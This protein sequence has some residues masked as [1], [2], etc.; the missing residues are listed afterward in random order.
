MN[1]ILITLDSVRASHLGCYGY[2]GTDTSVIDQIAGE[3]VLFENAFCQ[4]PNTWVSHASIFTGCNPNVH[5]LRLY[6]S[7]LNPHIP[8]L[9][10]ILRTAGYS[11]AGFPAHSLVGAVRG[12]QRGFEL[13]DEEDMLHDSV[14]GEG[15]KQNRAWQPTLEKAFRWMSTQPR[16]F[17]LWLHYMG[18]HWEPSEALSV[19]ESVRLRYSSLG[20]FYDAKISYADQVCIGALYDFLLDHGLLDDTLLVI[21]A[22][23]GED[24]LRK[25]DPPFRNQ[26][27]NNGLDEQVMHVPLII[28]APRLFPAGI[29]IEPVVRTVDI[30]PTLLSVLGIA[31]SGLA[32]DGIDLTAM[33]TGRDQTMPG[34]SAYMENAYKGYAGIRTDEW[35]L[36]LRVG[37]PPKKQTSLFDRARRR[38]GNE[39]RSLL[40]QA[41]TSPSNQLI[42]ERFRFTRWVKLDTDGFY[43]IA[44]DPHESN[45]LSGTTNLIDIES[46]L[47][48]HVLRMVR[49]EYIEQPDLSPIEEETIM[50]TLQ[51]LGYID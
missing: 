14:M 2:R 9:A 38:L 36:V 13:F 8:T 32:L 37:N 21:T 33:W 41:D 40:T 25:N 3:G 46:D 35:K 48:N 43:A 10:E 1:V 47:E 17:F 29:R 5:G 26:A 16:P 27:H 11:T 22:D 18:T 30:L 45:N 6:L 15:L 20:Q 23:H 19:P 28:R 51:S 7:S 39:L 44:E 50:H 49:R 24:D 34:L 42:N 4:A 12:F 31:Q